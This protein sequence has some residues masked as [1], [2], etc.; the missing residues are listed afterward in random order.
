ML[1]RMGMVGEVEE[2][3]GDGVVARRRGGSGEISSASCVGIEIGSEIVGASETRSMSPAAMRKEGARW[4]R[5]RGCGVAMCPEGARWARASEVRRA[6]GFKCKAA[7]EV[8]GQGRP[9][10]PQ[11]YGPTYYGPTYYGPPSQPSS[12][13]SS[14]LPSL[15][16]CCIHAT[17]RAASTSEFSRP[18]RRT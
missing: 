2:V 8:T 16:W 13:A 4:A 9:T 18:P 17:R 10:V 6:Y 12:V 5:A 14:K 15:R 1:G 11:L 3:I 7:V